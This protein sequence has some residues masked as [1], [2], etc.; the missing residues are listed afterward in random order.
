M[1]SRAFLASFD[2]GMEPFAS[3]GLDDTL[4][5]LWETGACKWPGV[6]VDVER[7]ASELGS[8]LSRAGKERNLAGVHAADFYLACG[9]AQGDPKAL[10]AFDACFLGDI[11]LYLAPLGRGE[12]FTDEIAQAMRE[13]LFVAPPGATPKIAEYNGLSAMGAWLRVVAVR[14]ALSALRKD[15]GRSPLAREDAALRA[16]IAAPDPELDFMKAR[17]RDDFREAFQATIEE[18]DTEKKALLRLHY[19]DGLTIDELATLFAVHR[20]TVARWIAR[21]RAQIIDLTRRKLGEHLG[22]TASEIDSVLRLVQSELERG[23]RELLGTA[24]ARWTEPI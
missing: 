19:M 22:M 3:A 5:E 14:L 21:C 4:F 10:V 6:A 16:T 9:C 12:S 18:L 17:Y 2:G 7:F 15:R 13:K 23:L 8:R 1:P 24:P 20:S 11:A